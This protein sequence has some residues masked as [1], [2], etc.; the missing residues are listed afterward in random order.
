M[1]PRDGA[2]DASEQRMGEPSSQSPS[3]DRKHDRSKKRDRLHHDEDV[4]GKAGK[5][6]TDESDASHHLHD[7]G[8]R[9]DRSRKTRAKTDVGAASEVEQSDANRGIDEA[10]KLI[11]ELLM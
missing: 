8:C 5:G 3:R 9:D 4:H 6:H 1:E 10:H 7:G 11:Q 2:N